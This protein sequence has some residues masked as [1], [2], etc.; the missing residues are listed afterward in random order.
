VLGRKAYRE[1]TA[2]LDELVSRGAILSY[3]TNLDSRRWRELI[4]VTVVAEGMDIVGRERLR[5]RVRQAL[6]PLGEK[7]AIEVEFAPER[8]DQDGV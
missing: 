8:G 5:L 1:A 4:R 3:A 7:A 6:E 2:A